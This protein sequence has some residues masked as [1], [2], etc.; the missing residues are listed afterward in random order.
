MQA[1]GDRTAVVYALCNAGDLKSQRLNILK[2]EQHVL[3]RTRQMN[4]QSKQRERQKLI[5]LREE[6]E[7]ELEAIQAIFLADF[8]MRDDLEVRCTEMH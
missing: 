2:V 6:Q 1:F 4:K 5:Q 3:L 7:A 8:V